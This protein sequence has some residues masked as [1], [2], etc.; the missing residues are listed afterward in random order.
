M[1]VDNTEKI[2]KLYTKTFQAERDAG[3]V[4]RQLT[5]VEGQQDELEQWLD[6]YESQV[7]EMMKRAGLDGDAA[8][9]GV[10]KERERTYVMSRVHKWRQMLTFCRYTMAERLTS[11]L[12]EVNRDL[13]DIILEINSV[14]AS[15]SRTKGSDDPV[16][17]YC[18][19]RR[20]EAPTRMI[21]D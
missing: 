1:L 17:R 12:D 21:I 16:S 6:S 19:H 14:S 4:E 13:E 10:D 2:S 3:E 11:R 9:G 18:C 8:G 7:D 15:L 20:V 5:L